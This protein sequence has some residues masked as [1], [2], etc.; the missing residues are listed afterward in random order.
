MQ[1]WCKHPGEIRQKPPQAAGEQ[2]GDQAKRLYPGVRGGHGGLPERLWPVPCGD[3]RQTFCVCC[4]D[5]RAGRLDTE[6]VRNC[7]PCTFSQI[8]CSVRFDSA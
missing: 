8:P 4:G 1:R 5:G 3:C 6:T 2:E 7:I